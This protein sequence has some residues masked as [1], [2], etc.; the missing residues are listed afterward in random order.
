[1][2]IAK[3]L[4]I[5]DLQVKCNACCQYCRYR[6]VGIHNFI[7]FLFFFSDPDLFLTV[8]G[9]GS[10]FNCFRIRILLSTTKLTVRENL[11]V[12]SVQL[13]ADLST[14][15][16]KLRCVITNPVLFQIH[17]LFDTVG[18]RLRISIKQSDPNPYQSE[19]LDWDP[20]RIK[21]KGWIR[22]KMVWIR[23]TACCLPFQHLK[24]CIDTFLLLHNIVTA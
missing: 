3:E 4:Y 22:I 18:I 20:D 6:S 5:N 21:V 8:S 24:S 9:S 17:N 23:N 2:G 12:S 16:I 10:V 1:M 19:K 13:L 11:C 15:K 14:R 7:L